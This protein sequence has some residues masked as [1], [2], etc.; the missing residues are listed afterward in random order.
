[1]KKYIN[2][3]LVYKGTK[4]ICHNFNDDVDMFEIYTTKKDAIFY[5][6]LWKAYGHDVK[7]VPIKFEIA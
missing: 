5:K 7:V 2:Y 1:M 6:A 4:N 3:A